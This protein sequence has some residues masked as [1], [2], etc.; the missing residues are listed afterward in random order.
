MPALRRPLLLALSLALAA[1]VPGLRAQDTRALPALGE[2]ASEDLGVGDE[3]RLGRRIMED[4][5]RDPAYLDDPELLAYL[6][7]IWRPLV[8]VAR[9]QAYLGPDVDSA[10]AWE[11]FLVKDRSVNAFALPGGFMGVHLGLIAMTDSA[12]ELASVL[13]HELAHITQRHI[14]RS[15]GAAQRTTLLGSAA[16]MLALIA[17]TRSGNVDM[18]QAAIAGGQAAIAQGQLNF[19]RDMEREADRIGFALLTGSGHS[20]RGMAAMFEQLAHANRF[21][22]SQ[23]FPYLRSHPL[24]TER[25]AEARERIVAT[26][27]PMSQGLSHELMRARARVLMAESTEA[28]RALAAAPPPSAQGRERAGRLYAQALAA[29]RLHDGSIARSAI[30]ALASW[31]QS[32]DAAGAEAAARGELDRLE[33][34]VA[35]LLQQPGAA[36]VAMARPGALEGRPGLLLHA[37]LGLAAPSSAP[38]ELRRAA[39]ALQVWTAEHPDDALAWL[40]LARTA[41]AA[42]LP[43]RA[44]RADA[45][46]RAAVG[47]IAG[48]VDRLR[49][50]QHAAGEDPRVDRIELQVIDARLRALDGQLQARRAE[51]RGQLPSR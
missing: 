43:W 47:D 48:A 17:A 44:R 39:E 34:E 41:R 27:P 20:A 38:E 18:A 5:R 29:G 11:A 4:I 19:S 36:R 35:L 22:D 50:A 21:N 46:A 10:F 25:I 16:M 37:E 14:A 24:T 7:T 12:D 9:Q 8:A 31:R 30:A 28:L 42:G 13:G 51:E 26:A 1:P 33:A 45:E 40:T 3:A 23:A 49:A 6:Q 32:D 2:S 15:V